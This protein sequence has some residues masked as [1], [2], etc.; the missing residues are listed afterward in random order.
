MAARIINH[1]MLDEEGVLFGTVAEAE[2]A[3]ASM[4]AGYKK[5]GFTITETD[6]NADGG[7]WYSVVDEARR[8]VGMYYIET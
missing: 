2:A 7:P 5:R 4:I 3:L 1:L 6:E 8:P